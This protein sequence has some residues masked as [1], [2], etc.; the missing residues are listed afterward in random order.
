MVRGADESWQRK[1]TS[2][3]SNAYETEARIAATRRPAIVF[4]K[5]VR[6]AQAIIGVLTA[7]TL[8]MAGKGCSYQRQGDERG[9]PNRGYMP[10]RQAVIVVAITNTGQFGGGERIA[11][12][13]PWAGKSLGRGLARPLRNRG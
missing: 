1:A 10:G 9:C 8:F 4:N 11:F 6:H 3:L 13:R 12:N 2:T 5:I 7:K